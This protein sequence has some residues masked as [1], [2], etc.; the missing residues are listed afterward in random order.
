MKKLD[1][2]A[3]KLFDAVVLEV[4][5]RGP[6][7]LSTAD[8]AR[9]AASLTEIK[10]FDVMTDVLMDGIALICQ[11]RIGQ[12]RFEEMG[13]PPRLACVAINGSLVDFLWAFAH[14]MHFH[15][16]AK[17]LTSLSTELVAELEST[18]EFSGEVCAKLSVVATSDLGQE[19]I[20]KIMEAVSRQ[21][22][23]VVESLSKQEVLAVATCCRKARFI[24]SRL[25]GSLS[26]RFEELQEQLSL[27]DLARVLNNFAT[28]NY[29]P[30]DK[31][32]DLAIHRMHETSGLSPTETSRLIWSL[33]FFNKLTVENS[34]PLFDHLKNFS[35]SNFNAL[36]TQKLLLTEKLILLLAGDPEEEAALIPEPLR[37]ELTTMWRDRIDFTRSVSPFQQVR[38]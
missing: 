24:C 10:H 3:D 17:L 27:S 37:S 13:R 4:L 23:S 6:D 18:R 2:R 26:R 12:I 22:P 8:L 31:L 16:D 30:G 35:R 36:D 28:S 7:R 32:L 1:N 5:H 15:H 9:L 38:N 20:C 33:A 19:N 14:H 29:N 34:R 21:L 11:K 25:M